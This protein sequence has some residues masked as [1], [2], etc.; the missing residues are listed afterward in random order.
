MR[1]SHLLNLER[2][3]IV[4]DVETTGS[5]YELDRVWEIGFIKVHPD[6]REKEYQTLINPGMPVP[7]E[8]LPPDITN[9]RLSNELPFEMLAEGLSNGIRNC[10]FCGYNV[11][12]D[13]KMLTSEFQRTKVASFSPGKVVDACQIFFKKEPRNLA[14][15]V[16]RYLKREHKDPHRALPDASETWQVLQ[17]QLQEYTD[18]PRTVDELHEM[19][20]RKPDPGFL[21][22]KRRIAIRDGVAMINF[23]RHKRKPLTEVPTGY[24]TWMLGGD[25]ANEV[26]E[27]VEKE[28]DNRKQ[29]NDPYT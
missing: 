15:A 17:A 16:K 13:L 22:S 7:K 3:L 26:K 1:L 9:E 29:T 14:A 24:L 12:F 27:A 28:L 25:F 5:D 4:L 19:F 18:L 8:F 11:E 20:E 10:D 23:G 6:G 21:D 2:P